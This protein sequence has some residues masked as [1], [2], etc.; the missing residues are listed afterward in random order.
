MRSIEALVRQFPEKTG[1]EILV[2]Q[3]QDKIEDQKKYDIIHAKELAWI[4]DINGNGGF[5][6][7]RF[8]LSQRFFYNVTNAQH[9]NGTIIC[10]V[11]IIMAFF[12]APNG[13]VKEGE[14]NYASNEFDGLKNFWE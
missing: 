1:A 4:K 8:G 12:G 7:G 6:K 2:I 13:S 11:E 10:D 14:V 5:Y 9:I 3:K